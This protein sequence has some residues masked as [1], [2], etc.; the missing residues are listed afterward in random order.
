MIQTPRDLLSTPEGVPYR[1]DSNPPRSPIHPWSPIP[2]RFKPLQ[3][4]SPPLKESHTETIQ[5]P[6]DLLSTPEGVLYR[7]NSNPSRSPIHPWSPIPRRFKPLQISSPPLKE[8]HTETIQT[9]PDLLSTP[10]V[11][12]RDNS[13]PF[14]SPNLLSTPE[15]VPYQDDSNPSRSPLHP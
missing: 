6:P 2:R 9:P 10:G 15:G 1:D 5:T 3:I 7:D 11:P 12:Y 4:S 13:N 14:R 8:S